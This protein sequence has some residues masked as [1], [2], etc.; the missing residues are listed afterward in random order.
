MG[1]NVENHDHYTTNLFVV[2]FG[3][4]SIILSNAYKY[5]NVYRMIAP[6]HELPFTHY[7]QLED[8]KFKVLTRTREI[9]ISSVYATSVFSNEDKRNISQYYMGYQFFMERKEL[10][11]FITTDTNKHLESQPILKYGFL[12]SV[13]LHKHVGRLALGIC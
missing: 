7:K 3:F 8:H 9:Q 4:A 13:P 6:R 5:D 1:Q 11:I 2:L 12:I 10:G